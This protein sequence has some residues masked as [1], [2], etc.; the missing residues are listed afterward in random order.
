[1]YI[2]FMMIQMFWVRTMMN[3]TLEGDDQGAFRENMLLVDDKTNWCVHVV[4]PVIVKTDYNRQ[5]CTR[6]VHAPVLLDS[7]HVKCTQKKVLAA[8]GL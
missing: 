6:Y 7:V 2:L 3:S 4:G 1:M 8:P 5:V